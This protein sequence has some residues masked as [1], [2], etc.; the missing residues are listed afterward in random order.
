M[1]N[2]P[3]DNPGWIVIGVCTV[4]IAGLLLVSVIFVA[5][6]AAAVRLTVACPLL[7]T[8]MLVALKVTRD[9]VSVVVVGPVGEAEPPH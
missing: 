2:V 5:V 4:A 7:P 8:A 6:D 1:V 9:T 3:V